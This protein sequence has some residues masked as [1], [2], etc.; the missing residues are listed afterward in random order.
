MS[1]LKIPFSAK[2]FFAYKH[3]QHSNKNFFLTFPDEE[4]AIVGY[5]NLQFLANSE[6]SDRE[7][8]DAV[9]HFPGLDT[10]PYDRV[11]PHVDILAARA[12]TLSILS[13][14]SS[15]KLVV[16]ALANLLTKLPE[17][18]LFAGSTVTLKVGDKVNIEELVMFLLKNGFNRAASAIDSGDFAIRGE[19]LDIVI[20]INQARRI[21]F[22]WETIESIRK[23]DV[24]TQMSGAG[25]ENLIISP[26]REVLLTPYTITNFRN[27]FLTIFGVNHT[28][29]MLYQSIISGIKFQG[30]EQLLPLFYEQL[31]TLSDYLPEAGIIYDNLSLQSLYEYERSY[32]DFY[33]SRLI[34]NRSSADLFYFALPPGY[35]IKEAAALANE[36]RSSDQ[37]ICLEPGSDSGIRSLE[38]LFSVALQEK[39]TNFDALFD[40]IGQNKDKI[41]IILCSSTSSLERLKTIA[42][43][44]EY[45][46][47]KITHLNKAEQNTINLAIVPLANGFITDQ[48]VFISEQDIFGD[49]IL[50]QGQR[51]GKRRLKN[52]LTELDNIDEGD[53]ITHKDHGVG[54]FERIETIVV[55]NTA[56]DCLK[57]IYA[58]NDILYLPVENIELIKKY[59]NDEIKLDKLGGLGWQRRRAKV[60]ERIKDIA[61]KLINITAA[62]HLAKVAPVHFDPEIYDQFCEKFPYNETDDQLVAIQD[63]KEDLAS[64]NLMDRLI[65]G[66]VGFG[67]TEVAMR[68]AFMTVFNSGEDN[69]Q[70]AIIS[71]TTIL[72]KQH[73]ESFIARFKDFKIQIAQLSRL[74]KASVAKEVKAGLASGKVSIIIGTHTLLAQDIK[75]KNLKLL[76]IDE[77][78][79]FGVTQKERLKELK[80]EVHILS[81]SATPIPR[82]LQMSMVGI[83]DLSIIATAPIDRLPVKT[84]VIPFDH[85]IIRDALM[86]ERFRGGSSF[87]VCPKIKDIEL[88]ENILKTHVPELTYKIAHGQMSSATIDTVMSEFCEGKF[89]I[90]LSTTIIE[91]GIDIPTANTIIIHRSDMLGLSQL[92]QLRGRVGR[93]KVRGHAYLTLTTA[94]V[95]SKHSLERLQVLQNIDS[96]GAGFT[97]A[98]HDMD[99]RGFGNLVGDEQSG[100][101][102][103]VGAELYQEM[104]DEAISE[105]KKQD[106]GEDTLTYTP[107]INLDLPIFIPASY[108]EDSS[109]RLAIY[110]RVGDL[111]DLGEIEAFKGEMI[112]RFGALPLEFD[113]LLQVVDIKHQ[114]SHL[115]IETLDSGPNGFVIKFNQNFDTSDMVMAFINKHPRNSKIKPDNKLIFLKKLRSDNI[116]D[117]AREILKEMLSIA[118]A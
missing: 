2:C 46:T 57:I 24:N 66:D 13:T 92:Y 56:H 95:M 26:S 53:L 18:E 7:L 19:I 15:P 49:K 3:F 42:D 62:R 68:A 89:D 38:P 28:N 33:Q 43:S 85:V 52:I 104:L 64:G 27:N 114:C 37:H 77:E 108:I 117:E 31:V 80:S 51:R 91:S 16:T 65:C 1:L 22:G 116:L 47:R 48:Y 79:H 40:F 61:G 90:L 96:L 109:L 101:I 118:K 70:V 86:R 50:I 105:L 44:Q 4:S 41:I 14:S 55:N 6:Q 72:C 39:K 84:T 58:D 98:S 74:V 9:L 93:G 59:G 112:D 69:P 67:K 8:R 54:Q 45:T 99:L 94:G 107:A 17:P 11:S 12:K 73:Y 87:Y 88:V 82:T 103:E 71:P 10:V 35:F 100:H 111:K 75:F 110:R 97:I 20:D 76:I 102:K 32:N 5:R 81:L 60:K 25:L 30:Y 115:K 23:F 106:T 113:N 21:N 34:A 83:K 29:N 36:L 78:Q 63:V